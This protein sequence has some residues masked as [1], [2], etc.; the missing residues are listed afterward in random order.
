LLKI[1]DAHILIDPVFGRSSPV[2]FYGGTRFQEPPFSREE[3]PKLDAPVK[4]PNP[5]TI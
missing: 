2:S 5:T 4:S 3:L 1:D